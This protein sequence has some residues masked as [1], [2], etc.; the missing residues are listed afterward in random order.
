MNLDQKCCYLNMQALNWG[1]TMEKHFIGNI[2]RISFS[3][4]GR[5]GMDMEISDTDLVVPFARLT[6]YADESFA[7]FALEILGM[8][9]TQE[10]IDGES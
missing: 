10:G 3:D 2:A 5:V 1:F 8:H 6:Q 4:N 9:F 7:D